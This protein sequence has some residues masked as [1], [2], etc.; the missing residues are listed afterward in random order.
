M[1]DFL[2]VK[3]WVILPT[4]CYSISKDFFICITSLHLTYTPTLSYFRPS[5]TAWAFVARPHFNE[6]TPYV[7]YFS[8]YV[9]E[10]ALAHYISEDCHLDGTLPPPEIQVKMWKQQTF[11]SHVQ[12]M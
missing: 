6:K 9:N 8:S 2:F 5:P 7:V 11:F 3:K 1:V 4:V 10:A 12:Q